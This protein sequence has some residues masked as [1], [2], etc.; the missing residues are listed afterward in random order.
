MYRHCLRS[1][2]IVFLLVCMA[3]LS[4][5]HLLLQ[6]FSA[7]WAAWRLYAVPADAWFGTASATEMEALRSFLKRK[8][9]EK[10]NALL[11]Q[12]HP[13]SFSL[14]CLIY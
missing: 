1:K 14:L 2:K 4:P 11:Q 5:L 8:S 13:L 7:F 10:D 6:G 9:D 12:A 3:A